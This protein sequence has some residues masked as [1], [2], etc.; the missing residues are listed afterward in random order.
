MRRLNFLTLSVLLSLVVFLS[1]SKKD[2]SPSRLVS[3]LEGTWFIEKTGIINDQDQEELTPY[4]NDERC[5]KDYYFFTES[6]LYIGDYE[7]V[8]NDDPNTP[9]VVERECDKVVKEY[10][11]SNIAGQLILRSNREDFSYT[12]ISVDNTYLKLLREVQSVTP[13]GVEKQIILLKRK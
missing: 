11:W 4:L 13:T 6:F 5:E 8:E 3:E 12:I 10:V 7:S 9:N 1:C 2:D